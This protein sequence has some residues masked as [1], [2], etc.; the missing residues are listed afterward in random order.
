[1]YGA[2]GAPYSLSAFFIWGNM[3]AKKSTK[4]HAKK[5]TKKRG[6]PKGN[7]NA[8][9]NNGGAPTK[10][11]PEYC[12]K[13]VEFFG[14]TPTLEEV[15]KKKLESGIIIFPTFEKFAHEICVTVKTLHEWCKEHI[16]FSQS[17]ERAKQMQKA[18]L[19]QC[20]LNDL[21]NA[22]FAKFVAINCTDM[23]E[24]Q[25]VEHSGGLQ[26]T[27]VELPAKKAIGEAVSFE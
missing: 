14:V 16:E 17:Y 21:Y 5:T 24:R 20:G 13:I 22:G 9:G 1:M 11:R 27:R 12:D 26:V 6:A 25:E 19:I 15:V 3:A 18:F 4:K 7:Q 8:L 23:R 2:E 10:Y